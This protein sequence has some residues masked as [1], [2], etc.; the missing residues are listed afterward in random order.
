[1]PRR[2]Q[3]PS[4]RY[5]EAGH[6]TLQSLSGAAWQREPTAGCPRMGVKGTALLDPLR[7]TEA[8]GLG[9]QALPGGLLDVAQ[10]LVA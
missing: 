4:T 9:V 2:P 3:S 6:S 10:G 5:G 8:L 1:M 7:G